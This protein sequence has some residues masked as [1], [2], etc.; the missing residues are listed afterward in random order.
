MGRNTK[1]RQ[2][3]N[4]TITALVIVLI[5]ALSGVAYTKTRPNKE[6]KK[7]VAGASIL[8]YQDP[9][10]NLT[11]SYSEDLNLSSGSNQSPELF[12]LTSEQPAFSIVAQYEEGE[13][14]RKLKTLG[15]DVRET[16]VDNVK[17]QLPTTYQE[18]EVIEER[19]FDQNGSRA[20]EVK[21][22]YVNK[23]KDSITQRLIILFKNEN[24]VST[25][26]AQAL[27]SNF[28]TINKSYLSPILD[29]L[30]Y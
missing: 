4:Y 17:K 2:L 20:A 26:S 8:Q 25:V 1:V 22:K 18:A 9:K 29:S 19:V 12:K 30:K 13:S 7:E 10:T 28:E 23:K 6:V 21:F 15:S 14:I 3:R 24:L 27:T 5:L 11:V 16:I